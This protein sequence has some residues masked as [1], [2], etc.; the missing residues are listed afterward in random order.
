MFGNF[1]KICHAVTVL[2]LVKIIQVDAVS[3]SFFLRN[4]TLRVYLSHKYILCPTSTPSYY[5][6]W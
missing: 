4:K 5:F 6:F 1:I 3:S 2:V